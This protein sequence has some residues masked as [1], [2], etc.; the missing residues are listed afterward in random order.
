MRDR[1]RRKYLKSTNSS[2]TGTGLY[3]SRQSYSIKSR[4]AS[5]SNNS[6]TIT[7]PKRLSNS[8]W[9]D[10]SSDMTLKASETESRCFGQ[11]LWRLVLNQR[12]YYFAGLLFNGLLLSFYSVM[13][14]TEHVPCLPP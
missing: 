12:I 5:T 10:D 4:S 13:T 3:T 2:T 6:S 8:S 9:T 11:F 1:L 7:D 14:F